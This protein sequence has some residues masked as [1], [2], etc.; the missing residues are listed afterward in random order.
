[1]NKFCANLVCCLIP[2]KKKRDVVRS[3]LIGKKNL[4]KPQNNNKLIETIRQELHINLCKNAYITQRLIT[5]AKTNHN[6]FNKFKG[7]FRGKIV[8]L[9]GAGPTVNYFEPIENAIYVGCNRAFLFDRVN[10]DY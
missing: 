3:V 8:V 10:F 7:A 5:A 9:I 4:I 1:M 6:A 2:N